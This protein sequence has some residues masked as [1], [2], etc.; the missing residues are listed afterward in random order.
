MVKL[1]VLYGRPEDEVAFDAHYEGTHVALVEK[2]P[3][4]QRF[5][6]GKTV[7]G[8]DGTEAPYHYVAELSFEDA[9]TLQ[10]AMATPEGVAAGGDV[11]N[12][13]SGGVMMFVVNA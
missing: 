10:A 3:N 1:M 13:A 7:G 12:F 2:I 9:D 11:A 5:E 6:H 8:G 4:L